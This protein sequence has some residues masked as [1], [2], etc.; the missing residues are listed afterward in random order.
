MRRLLFSAT[1]GAM[2]PTSMSEISM[3]QR[4]RVTSVVWNRTGWEMATRASREREAELKL[5]SVPEFAAEADEE[6]EE[7][8]KKDMTRASVSWFII[9]CFLTYVAHAMLLLIAMIHAAVSA[10]S[11]A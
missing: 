8:A 9:F 5:T 4:E 6:E 7:V 2:I 10:E 1:D 11:S 3:S